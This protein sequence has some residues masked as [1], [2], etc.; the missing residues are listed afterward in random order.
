MDIL[1]KI[2]LNMDYCMLFLWYCF[3]WIIAI[4]GGNHTKFILPAISKVF[5]LMAES[6]RDKQILCSEK[7]WPENTADM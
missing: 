6:Q 1:W 4:K 3:A 7:F 2:L 5:S